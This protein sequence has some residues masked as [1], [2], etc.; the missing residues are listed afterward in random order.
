MAIQNQS[1]RPKEAQDF[2]APP[3]LALLTLDMMTRVALGISSSRHRGS[4]A[5]AAFPLLRVFAYTIAI[6]LPHVEMFEMI[7]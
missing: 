5:F 3:S 7:V 6:G 2:S 4:V 1:H